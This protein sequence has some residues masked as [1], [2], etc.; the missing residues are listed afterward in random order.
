M[1]QDVPVRNSGQEINTNR[2]E[3][4]TVRPEKRDKQNKK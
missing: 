3:V 1:E 2:R 4:E